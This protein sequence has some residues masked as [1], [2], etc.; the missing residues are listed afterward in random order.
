MSNNYQVSENLSTV[1]YYTWQLREREPA[2]TEYKDENLLQMSQ[3]EG[4][5][6]KITNLKTY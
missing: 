2:C 1:R 6:A 4:H 3:R 5:N